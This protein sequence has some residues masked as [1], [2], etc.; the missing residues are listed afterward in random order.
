MARIHIDTT[1]AKQRSREAPESDRVPK[2]PRP[3]NPMAAP[4]NDP[5]KDVPEERTAREPFAVVVRDVPIVDLPD[6]EESES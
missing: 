3:K 5:P 2:T 1:G 6:R 4:Q